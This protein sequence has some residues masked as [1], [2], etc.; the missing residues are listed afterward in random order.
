M[1]YSP[2]IDREVKEKL[3]RQFDHLP[4]N[5]V[6]TRK[7]HNWAGLVPG[8]NYARNN[9][10]ACTFLW[11][12]LVILFNG[13]MVPCPQDFK[14]SLKLGNIKQES[15]DSVFNGEKM[16]QL[17]EKIAKQDIRKLDTLQPLVTVCG[18]ILLWG[19]PLIT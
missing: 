1:E 12:A 9:Y 16:Q 4:L 10:V 7:P 19:F 15:I 18:G 11:Y 6:V 5:R 3:L 14:A 2:D 17:R 13:D 8:E